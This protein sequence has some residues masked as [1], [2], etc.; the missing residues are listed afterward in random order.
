MPKHFPKQL[1]ILKYFHFENHFF[2]NKI[3]LKIPK[4]VFY[5]Y[6]SIE[7]NDAIQIKN[8]I[9]KTP[10]IEYTIKFSLTIKERENVFELFFFK[11]NQFKIKQTSCSKSGRKCKL[12]RHYK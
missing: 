11:K 5:S 3:F 10:A 7:F 9:A 1:L 12:T 6:A 4:C 2:E 8:I